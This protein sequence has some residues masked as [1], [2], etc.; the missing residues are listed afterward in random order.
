[1]APRQLADGLI[2]IE[3]F[4]GAWF[5]IAHGMV[6]KVLFYDSNSRRVTFLVRIAAGTR[7]APYRHAAAEERYVLEGGC[8]CGG[9]ELAVGDYHRAEAGTEHHDTSSDE[10]CLLLVISSSQNEMLQ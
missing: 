1:M 6:A 8:L 9:R 4:D 3:A 7:Y 5:N 2:F 10:G